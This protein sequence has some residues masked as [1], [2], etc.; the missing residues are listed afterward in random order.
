MSK[1]EGIE[2]KKVGLQGWRAF[3][4]VFLSGTVAALLVFG[5]AVGV[6]KTFFSSLVSAGSGQQTEP[7]P[8][9]SLAPGELDLCGEVETSIE[10]AYLIERRDSEGVEDTAEDN[11]STGARTIKDECQWTI[12]DQSKQESERNDWDLEFSYTVIAEG[13][14][15]EREADEGFEDLKTQ[16][17]DDFAEVGV[18]T[19]TGETGD[20]AYYINGSTEGNPQQSHYSIVVK[21]NSGFYKISM[22]GDELSS[23]VDEINPEPFDN[24][25]YS[26]DQDINYRLEKWIPN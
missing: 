21:V 14:S 6:V 3:L 5:A 1:Q 20:E 16:T 19:E 22:S 10:G 9:K 25:V 7:E 13:D 12:E 23:G 11:S 2:R 8:R 4:V 24:L 15:K 17:R 18:E 26:M